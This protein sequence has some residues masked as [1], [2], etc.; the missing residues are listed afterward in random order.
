MTR[1]MYDSTNA[2][3]I[4]IDA[5]AAGYDPSGNATLD[6]GIAWSPAD[7]ARFSNPVHIARFPGIAS[8]V[9][10]YETGDFPNIA[11]VKEW[12]LWRQMNGYFK[13]SVY[14]SLDRQT[15]VASGLQGLF[16]D[17]W[18]AHY[19]NNTNN[20]EVSGAVAKQYA[21]SALTG[22]DYDLS[23]VLDDRWPHRSNSMSEPEVVTGSNSQIDPRGPG[24]VYVI[25]FPFKLY[26]TTPTEVSS[27]LQKFGQPNVITLD[28]S[29]LDRYI[30]LGNTGDGIYQQFDP[31]NITTEFASV[32]TQLAAINNVLHTLITGSGLTATQAQQLSA[33]GQSVAA[34]EAALKTA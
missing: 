9:A 16:Y 15:E 7:F 2:N 26:C 19:D 21:D 23:V 10:D 24:A 32:A 28:Q 17:S 5:F 4:P 12:I 30:D 33:I 31:N 25:G 8:D 14:F 13:P 18:Y 6:V 34:I 1:L 11:S 27:F 22:H 29:L 20:I 3:A